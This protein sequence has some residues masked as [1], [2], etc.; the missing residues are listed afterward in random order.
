MKR[1]CCVLA[2]TAFVLGIFATIALQCFMGT[3]MQKCI[4]WPVTDQNL[5]SD[6]FFPLRIVNHSIDLDFHEHMNN[7]STTQPDV[8]SK[9]QKPGCEN[10][11]GLVFSCLSF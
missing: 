11:S 6:A 7:P 8:V 1:L 3:L 10:M 9:P 2:L 5:T 4:S